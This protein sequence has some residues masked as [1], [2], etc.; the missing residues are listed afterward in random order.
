MLEV[1]F[2]PD[3]VLKE[4]SRVCK[5]EELP[6]IREAVK[7][8]IHIC[9]NPDAPG[10]GLAANQVG[11]PMR[12]F[13]FKLDEEDLEE[14]TEGLKEWMTAVNPIIVDADKDNPDN[15]ELAREG[16][17]SLPGLTLHVP[18]F[19]KIRVRFFDENG[20]SWDMSIEGNIARRFQHEYDHINGVCITKYMSRR[21]RESGK[22]KQYMRN[23]KK[24]LKLDR[25]RR[26]G[27]PTPEEYIKTLQSSVRPAEGGDSQ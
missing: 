25:S 2:Y 21:R 22:Y 8:M 20:K 5:E 10:V 7:E 24:Q 27:Q 15:V 18:R 14:G 26:K 23:A 17:L 9:N 6:N 11:I 4:N 12:F 16:C 3:P 19:K 13:I 1:H